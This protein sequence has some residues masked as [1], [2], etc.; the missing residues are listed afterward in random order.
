[1]PQWVNQCFSANPPVFSV[2]QERLDNMQHLQHLEQQMVDCLAGD[3][4]LLN[5]LPA[6]RKL[7]ELKK[8]YEETQER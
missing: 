4:R 1:M 2:S 6:T 3:V 7:A 8:Q 5:D